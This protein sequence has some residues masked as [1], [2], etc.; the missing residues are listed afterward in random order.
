[1]SVNQPEENCEHSEVQE[2]QEVDQQKSQQKEK[3]PR[4]KTNEMTQKET[5]SV[6]EG[7]EGG[8]DPFPDIEPC[9]KRRKVTVP[10]TDD[11]EEGLVGWFKDNVIFYN[12][13]LRDFKLKDNEE[14][15]MLEP[16]NLIYLWLN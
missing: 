7:D 5:Q 4:V 15:M 12:Q 3:N 9:T 8:D 10:L 13:S 2:V 1:M 11:Q 6:E 16:K 14:R